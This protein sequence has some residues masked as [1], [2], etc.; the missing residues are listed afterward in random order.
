MYTTTIKISDHLAE[1]CIAKYSIDTSGV[2]R[3]PPFTD[4]Y[5]TISDLTRKRPGNTIDSGNVE[6]ALPTHDK[7]G[8]TIRKNPEI[9]NFIYP[10]AYKI[11]NRKIE[12]MFW[13]EVHDF[14]LSEKLKNG[15]YYI[16]SAYIFL[17]KYDISS[18]SS[19]AITKNFKRYRDKINPKEIRD[20]RKKK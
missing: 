12:L 15:N 9:Y 1:Y 5:R 18:I 3:F 14:L 2:V 8:D 11:I 19:D 16:D 17:N 4:V 10:D 13:D 20:Y 7:N 6:I